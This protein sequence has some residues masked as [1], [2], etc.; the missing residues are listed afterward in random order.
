MSAKAEKKA[1]DRP[2][3][4]GAGRSGEQHQQAQQQKEGCQ[5]KGKNRWF[6]RGLLSVCCH[7]ITICY[8]K[9]YNKLF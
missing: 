7:Y 8:I 3:A 2:A 1:I 9:Q 6:H 4:K 5:P